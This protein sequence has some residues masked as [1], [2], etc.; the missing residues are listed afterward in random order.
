MQHGCQK[1]T[2]WWKRAIIYQ[3]FPRSFYDSNGD[4]IGD[5]RGILDRLD[6]IVSLGVDTIWINPI[7][8]STGLDNGYDIVDHQAIQPEYG[9][10]AD[11]DELLEKAH[12]K[13]L[14][15][16][17]DMVINHTSDHHEWFQQARSSRDNPYYNY[18]IWWPAEKGDPPNRCGFFDPAGK[19]W[20]YNEP[21]NSFYLHYFAPEQPDLNW[22]N[23][24]MRQ[25][26]YDMLRFWL[27]KGVDGF[28]FDALTFISKDQEFPAITPE[29]LKEHYDND[30]G[31]YYASGPRL[32][33]YLNDLNREVFAHYP[34]VVTI[35]EGPGVTTDN[36]LEF[37]AEDRH[38]LN[39]LYHFDGMILGQ[40]PGAFKKPDPGGYSR[41]KWREVY[42][43]WSNVF[44]EKGWG[45]LYLGNHD[46]PR[47]VSRWGDDSA[48]S[49]K[50]LF[51]FL[52]TM[53]A[54]P[55][56]YNGDELGMTNIRFTSIEDYE[57]IETRLWYEKL[58]A[59]GGDTGEFLKDQ[60]MTG[61]DNGRTPFQWNAKPNAGFTTGQPWFKINPNF[62]VI[63]REAEEKD[64]G[65]VLHFVR[66]LI[67]LRREYPVLVDGDYRLL[68]DG[69]SS[70]HAYARSCGETDKTTL[71][72]LLNLSA[73]E[74][75]F[76]GLSAAPAASDILINSYPVVQWTSRG[77]VLAP[78]QSL[79]LILPVFPENNHP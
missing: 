32:H 33:E 28:R 70:I 56:I 79:V 9:T 59:E 69:D 46:Q 1:H 45:T 52:L 53:R 8:R 50:L 71:A 44:N 65:S 78:W 39:L 29:I 42:T 66:R 38:E 16:I 17:M 41:R 10:M 62:T 77:I 37:V 58:K 27:D 19:A 49:A 64:P 51:T 73:K 54:T 2:E 36:V 23:P 60:Q 21:T 48:M 20:K 61:R 76:G 30:W 14:R 25:K 40:L 34:N 15:L 35:G 63:N 31:H 12:H 26:I 55:F 74:T 5:L 47:M 72:I 43:R 7:Y 68:A 4:G 18:Y 24:E 11:F 22:D 67:R 57:D 6:Y 13:N 3:I 75:P